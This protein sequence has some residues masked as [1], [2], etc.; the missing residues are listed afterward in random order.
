MH[1]FKVIPISEVG[2]IFKLVKTI[3]K[4]NKETKQSFTVEMDVL[5]NEKGSLSEEELIL[6]CAHLNV[7]EERLQHIESD[8][9][10]LFEKPV[11]PRK[12]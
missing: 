4:W 9:D 11:E 12:R 2:A 10:Y 8:L 6:F 7:T 1:I 5:R 3:E